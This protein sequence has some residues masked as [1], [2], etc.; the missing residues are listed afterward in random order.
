[1]RRSSAYRL[2]LTKNSEYHVRG[3]VC[4]GVRDR[5]TGEWFEAHAALGRPLA[6]AYSDRS[7]NVRGAPIPMVGEPLIFFVDGNPV[8]TSTVLTIE[9][10]EHLRAG[11]GDAA[12]TPAR[13]VSR[14]HRRR[15]ISRRNTSI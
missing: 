14:A 3:N 4:H 5:R 1:M 15:R 2:F 9:E 11:G 12:S 10:R 8:E 7:G 6:G 13:L